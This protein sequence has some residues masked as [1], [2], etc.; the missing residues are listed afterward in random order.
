MTQGFTYNP[1]NINMANGINGLG[2]RLNFPVDKPN[3]LDLNDPLSF[4]ITGT[5]PNF[6]SFNNFID[7][8]GEEVYAA[9]RLQGYGIDV[10]NDGD[11]DSSSTIYSAPGPLPLLGI[12]AAFRA[13]RRLRRRLSS[14]HLA[15]GRP[16]AHRPA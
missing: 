2:L 10:N 3:R 1:D 13:S 15:A 12:A 6:G 9:A 4:I 14:A 7:I 16:Q 8:G 11:G 5:N